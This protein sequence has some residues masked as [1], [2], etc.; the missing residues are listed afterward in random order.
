MILQFL[1]NTAK[2]ISQHSLFSSNCL[3]CKQPAQAA[4][5]CQYCAEELP[6]L[7]HFCFQCGIPL[8]GHQTL[9]SQCQRNPPAWDRLHILSDYEFPIKGL[10]HQ[11]KYEKNTLAADLLSQFLI[12]TYQSDEYSHSQPEAILPVPLHWRRN[13][14]RGFNQCLELARPISRHLDIPIRGDLLKR[15]R[16]TKVQAGLSQTDRQS[17][18]EKAFIIK[19]HSYKHVILLD[20]V[21]TTGVTATTLVQLLKA[22]GCERVDVWAVCRTQLRGE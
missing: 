21:V 4:L 7:D 13:C 15:I 18:L 20:D 17:N 9:C 11:L 3:L 12:D 6:I 22:N 1:R 5:I 14:Y 8:A 10:V 16:H 19:P 2:Q